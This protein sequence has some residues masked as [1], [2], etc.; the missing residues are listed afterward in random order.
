M[1]LWVPVL[2]AA[3]QGTPLT[4]ETRGMFGTQ[5]SEVLVGPYED[6]GT[7][8]AGGSLQRHRTE[9]AGGSLV[10]MQ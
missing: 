3:P 7:K 2:P 8:G 9:G 10:R 6:T 1:S 4:W 5:R